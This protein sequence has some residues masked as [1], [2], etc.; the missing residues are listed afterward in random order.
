MENLPIDSKKNLIINVLLNSTKKKVQ[1]TLKHFDLNVPHKFLSP[2]IGSGSKMNVYAKSLDD[3]YGCPY[4]LHNE[5]IL[6]S[7]KW[8]EYLIKNSGILKSFIAWHLSLFLHSKNS[9]VPNITNKI[10]KP[11]KRNSLET[12]KKLYWDIVIKEYGYLECIYTGKKLYKSSYAV[13][14]FLPYQ[15]VVHDL[16]W[17]LI[18][19]DPIFNSIKSDKLPRFDKYF[20]SFYEI[21]HTGVEVIKSIE[22]KK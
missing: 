11:A 9:N 1:K 8:K 2:W 7:K 12:Q 22:P 13:E 14:H 16:M 3:I 20:K 4:E 19:A 17:N 18:P 5:Y 10:I 15:Y 21:Q 6:I